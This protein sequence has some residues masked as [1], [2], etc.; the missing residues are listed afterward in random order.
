MTSPSRPTSRY[1]SSTTPT[2]TKRSNAAGRIV[3]LIAIGLVVVL[4]YSVFDY[5]KKQ[6]SRTVT[7]DFISLEAVDDN[8]T[9]M[10]IDVSRKDV[11]AP[12]YCIV[13]AV[14]Y[15]HAEVGRREVVLPAGGQELERVAVELPVR[16][17]AVSG[18][19]YGCSDNLPFYMDPTSTFYDAR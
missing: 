1:G 12:S 13:T 11:E 6:E 18:R 5:F 9:R 7:A 10:W 15:A 2:A 16:G 8:T 14:N 17:P 3:A 19:V 4:L